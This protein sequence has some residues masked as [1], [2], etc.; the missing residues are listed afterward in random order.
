MRDGSAKQHGPKDIDAYL[1]AVPADARAALEKLRKT[2]NAAVPEPVEAI[3]YQMPTIK[4]RGRPL[5]AFAALTNHCSLFPM[6]TAAITAHK[7]ELA[8]Y[9]TSKGTIRFPASKPLP[10]A[11]VRKLVRARIAEINA[12]IE[13]KRRRPRKGT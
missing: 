10:V 11:L 12:A 3:S 2:I 1:A 13:A 9:E 6:S 4:Y 7:D 5:V 8:R